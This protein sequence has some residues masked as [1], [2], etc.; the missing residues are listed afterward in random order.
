MNY[1]FKT[2]ELK[3]VEKLVEQ[4]VLTL[5]PCY[6]ETG[7]VHFCTNC[8]EI[9]LLVGRPWKSNVVLEKSLKSRQKMIVILCINPGPNT[10]KRQPC[11]CSKTMNWWLCWCSKATKRWPCW[12]PKPV[13]WELNVFLCKKLS[14]VPINLHRCL[15]RERKR[16]IAFFILD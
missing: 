3:N 6:N 13:L 9:N 12:C 15:P 8:C 7:N 11:W 4:T 10:I 1:Q 14:F 2:S 5:K 16:S